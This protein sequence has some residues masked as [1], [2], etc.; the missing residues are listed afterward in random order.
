MLM[1]VRKQEISRSHTDS[2]ASI[3]A[4]PLGTPSVQRQSSAGAKHWC[5]EW[6][7]REGGDA[8]PESPA[9]LGAGICLEY[10]VKI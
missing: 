5:G 2:I 1:L 3:L 7:H 6:E 9:R 10:L 8:A 4:L